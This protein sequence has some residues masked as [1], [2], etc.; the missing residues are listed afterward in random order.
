M[1]KGPKG[2]Y[3][4]IDI[5]LVSVDCGFHG[6]SFYYHAPQVV[7]MSCVF[8]HTSQIVHN[9][10]YLESRLKGEKEVWGSKKVT[11]VGVNLLWVIF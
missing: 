8:F 7:F 11:I 5:Q 2:T 10:K 4:A 9:K 1:G 3:R 6:C